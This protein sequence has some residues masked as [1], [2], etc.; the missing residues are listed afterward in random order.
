MIGKE[1]ISLREIL[2]RRASCVISTPDKETP[3]Y[4]WTDGIIRRL[5]GWYPWDLE[6]DDVSSLL[7][8]ISFRI[9]ATDHPDLL[10]HP[11]THLVHLRNEPD[12]IQWWSKKN[13][14]SGDSFERL[15][16]RKYIQCVKMFIPRTEPVIVITGREDQ[17]PVVDA[18]RGDGYRIVQCRKV[19][20]ERELSALEDRAF[21][22]RYAKDGIFIG[23]KNGST[24]SACLLET[25]VRFCKSVH[26]DL[27]NIR[28]TVTVCEQKD[29]T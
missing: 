19:H 16:N 5:Q 7:K 27:D 14:T 18:L 28:S 21:A 20:R 8:H 2:S 4:E 1:R 11:R 10:P 24:F 3:I 22:E 12:A 9:V 17:N 25:R 26:M 6:S 29:K 13:G 15:L 23:C